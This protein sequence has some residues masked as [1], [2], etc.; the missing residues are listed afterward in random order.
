LKKSKKRS[1]FDFYKKI[2][3]NCK[4]EDYN[5]IKNYERKRNINKFINLEEKVPLIKNENSEI[6][7]EEKTN[8]F[9]FIYK[10]I[11]DVY[12]MWL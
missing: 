4:M 7:E 10:L 11:K 5:Y 1:K 8:C 3:K 9:Q 6:I 12:E 2:Y